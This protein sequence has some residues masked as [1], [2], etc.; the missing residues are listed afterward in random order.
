MDR[1]IPTA[2]NT[3]LA[4]QW[5]QLTVGNDHTCGIAQGG[6]AYC[7]GE[8]RRVVPEYILDQSVPLPAPQRGVLTHARPLPAAGINGQRW[9]VDGDGRLG[10][11][12]TTARSVPTPVDASLAA[13]WVQL[14]AGMYHTC[15]IA[16]GGTAYCWG[17]LPCFVTRLQLCT[18]A[19]SSSW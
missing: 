3:T 19:L 1:S 12:T 6:T 17:T 7:W 16:Q 13:E 10:D 9:E 18:C 14:S 11:G 2:V 5:V 8:R 15:G 4:A